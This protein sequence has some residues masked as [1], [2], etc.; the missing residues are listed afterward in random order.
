MDAFCPRCSNPLVPSVSGAFGICFACMAATKAL[1]YAS[2]LG[3][4]E[5]PAGIDSVLAGAALTKRV[6]VD[7]AELAAWRK[8]VRPKARKA[9]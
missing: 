6:P 7:V 5:P 3:Q 9:A 1:V 4:T 2:L 8:S